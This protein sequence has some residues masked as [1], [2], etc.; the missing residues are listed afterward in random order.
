M[1]DAGPLSGIMVIDLTRVLAGPLAT[2]ILADLGARV[3]KVE[4]PGRGDD[5]RQFGPPFLKDAAGDDTSES[6]YYLAVNRGKESLTLDLAKPR[7]QAIARSL[8]VGS[9]LLFENFKAGDLEKFG[10]G[11]ED[12]NRDNPGLIYCSVTGFGQTGPSR[13]RAGYDA[14]VQA[15]SGLMSIT[16]NAD[17]MPGGG[18]LRVGVPISDILTG[19]YAVIAVLAAL[20]H[21]QSTGAGQRIDVALLDSTVATLVNQAMNYLTT[22]QSPG[23]IGNTHPNIVPYQA[24]PTADGHIVLAIGNDTQFVRFCA[25]V[26]RPELAEDSRF[27]SNIERVRNRDVLIPLLGKIMATRTTAAWSTALEE[28]SLPSGPINTIEEVFA[29]PQVQARGMRIELA[30]PLAGVVPLVASPMRLS[31][32]P[33]SYHLAPPLL[34]E[35]TEKILQELGHSAAEIGSLKKA[36]VV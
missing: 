18:P 6:A 31:A 22:G 2:M 19:M 27:V 5:T 17:D 36:G 32:T 12:L 14:L 15:M 9:D 23:R 35:H 21:R 7:G 10:L 24:F 26:G 13:S 3:I 29:N 34:G 30:H 16:G 25:L 4:R 33:V 1:A 11:Y 20:A 28:A 8:A